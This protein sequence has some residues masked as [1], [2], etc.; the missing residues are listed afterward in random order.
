MIFYLQ[1]I[2]L[3]ISRIGEGQLR[4]GRLSEAAH[5]R[6]LRPLAF[7]R[8]NADPGTD[9]QIAIAASFGLIIADSIFYRKQQGQRI[10]EKN[11]AITVRKD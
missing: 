11:P 2:G 3:Y 6:T 4:Q 1:A 9:T 7:A 10:D 8:V 5:R